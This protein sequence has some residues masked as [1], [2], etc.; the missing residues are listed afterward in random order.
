[1]WNTVN[2]EKWCM[3]V[4]ISSSRYIYQDT[5]IFKVAELYCEFEEINMLIKY[6]SL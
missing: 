6:F 5:S 4:C 3:Y 2:M 1:M